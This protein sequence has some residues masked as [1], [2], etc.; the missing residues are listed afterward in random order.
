MEPG[1]PMRRGEE[2]AVRRLLP[3]AGGGGGS[4]ALGL[5]GGGCLSVPVHA[6][7]AFCFVTD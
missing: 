7:N 4:E 3:V 5:G 6:L 2:G 1:G